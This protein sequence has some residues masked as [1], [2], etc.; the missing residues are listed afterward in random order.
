[1][2]QDALPCDTVTIYYKNVEG[3][4][5][6]WA[7]MYAGITSPVRCMKAL[8]PGKREIVRT[9]RQVSTARAVLTTVRLMSIMDKIGI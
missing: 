5:R 3:M 7:N 9:D 8:L 4:D 2:V 6:F 1:M